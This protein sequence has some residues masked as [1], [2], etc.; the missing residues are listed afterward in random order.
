MRERRFVVENAGCP[1]CAERVYG[2][3]SPLGIIDGVTVDEDADSVTVS[4]RTGNSV[5][6]EEINK[7]L[8]AASEGAGH[9][10]RV[11]ADSWRASQ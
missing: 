7:V 3:L 4:M 8:A 1:A 10:Y 9:H 2:A 6:Q 5:G 11:L